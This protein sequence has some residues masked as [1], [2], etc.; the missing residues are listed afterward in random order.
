MSQDKSKLK[1]NPNEFIQAVLNITPEDLHANENGKISDN[2]RRL[3]AKNRNSWNVGAIAIILS[4]TVMVV[5]VMIGSDVVAP[6][7]LMILFVL[8]GLPILIGVAMQTPKWLNSNTDLRNGETAYVEGR[9]WQEIQGRNGIYAKQNYLL[10]I[11]DMTFE[12]EQDIFLAFRNGD[13]YRIYYGPRSKTI[14]GAEWLIDDDPFVHWDDTYAEDDEMNDLDLED[15]DVTDYRLQ[16][17]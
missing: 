13:P 14:L 2:Q 12:V 15:S 16:N 7:D 6:N 10:H 1:S 3:I 8:V 11:E 9:I 4:L 17:H 5:G